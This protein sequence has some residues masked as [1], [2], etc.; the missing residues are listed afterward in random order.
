VERSLPALVVLHGARRFL[1]DCGEGAQ[2]QL[3]KSGLG[4][5]RLDTVLLTHGHLDHI[6]GIG[7][8]VGTLALFETGE[9]LTV[10]G[11]AWALR[12]V[13]RLLSGV[14]WPGGG[15]PIRV[16]LVALTPGVVLEDDGFRLRAFPVRH[17]RAED[18]FGFAFEELPRRPMLPER[19]AALDVPAGPERA[20]LARGE[21]VVL[22]D[23]R[24]VAPDDVLGPAQPG[25]KLVVVGDTGSTAE[26]ASEVAGADAL[27]IEATYLERDAALAAARGHLTAARAARLAAEAGVGSLHL[28]HLSGRYRPWEIEA[29]ART[30]FPNAHV[31]HDFDRVTVPAER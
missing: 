8:L 21:A 20:R 3:L 28:N 27:V 19:L 25:T 10:H 1:V 29:E 15:P 18:C 24:R 31:A 6:L 2:R 11:G 5:R 16:D 30:I 7:G 13:Q 4:L 22:P 12:A 9:R 26:L 14:I 17:G 23:G